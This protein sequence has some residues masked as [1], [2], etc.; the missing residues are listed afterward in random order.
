M[1]VVAEMNFAGPYFDEAGW[2]WLLS[3][4]EQ[5]NLHAVRILGMPLLQVYE[6]DHVQQ[7]S[8]AAYE[9]GLVYEVTFWTTPPAWSVAEDR[10]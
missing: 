4:V 8:D 9:H 1:Q 7:I 3:Y 6:F 5:N 10:L 2:A